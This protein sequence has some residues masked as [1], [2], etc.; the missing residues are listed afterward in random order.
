MEREYN[1]VQNN[2][3]KKKKKTENPITDEQWG[4]EGGLKMVY[5][6]FLGKFAYQ[7]VFR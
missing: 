4:W 6:T 2:P 7:T 3:C 5:K 1:Y